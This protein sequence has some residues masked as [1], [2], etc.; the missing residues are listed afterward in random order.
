MRKN[1]KMFISNKHIGT[2]PNHLKIQIIKNKTY[3]RDCGHDASYYEKYDIYACHHCD[4]WLDPCA[5]KKANDCPFYA[6]NLKRK[7]KPSLEN[8]YKKN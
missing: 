1:L 3:C 7:H 2:R 5:C 6:A 4:Q 8:V